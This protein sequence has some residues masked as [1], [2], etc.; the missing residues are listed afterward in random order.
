MTKSK[1]SNGGLVLKSI[2][3]TCEGISMRTDDAGNVL[4]I[5]ICGPDKKVGDRTFRGKVIKTLTKKE[6]D[7]INGVFNHINRQRKH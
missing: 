5:E 6:W 7:K 2:I 1:E 3:Y 4:S